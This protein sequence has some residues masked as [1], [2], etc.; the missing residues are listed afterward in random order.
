MPMTVI[1]VTNAPP[2][3]RGD[4]TKWMQ[5]IATGVYIGNFNSR[6]REQLWERVTQ[7]VGRGQATISYTYRNESGYQFQ[8]YQT[9]RQNVNYDGIPL[10]LIP[11]D[12]KESMPKLTNGFSNASIFRKAKKYSAISS[13][14]TKTRRDFVV[15]D[16]E[17]D[18]LSESANQIIEIGA[19]KVEGDHY[20][21]MNTLIEYKGDLPAEI[22]SLTGITT[23]MLHAGGIPISDAL[24]SLSQFVGSLPIVGYS[25]DFDIRFINQQLKKLDMPLLTNKTY[26]LLRFVK[27]EKM[28]LENYRLETALLEYEID[29]KVPH[30]ALEDA[31]LTYEL[32]MKVNGFLKMLDRK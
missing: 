16:I 6:I 31:K 32:A 8:T 28:F 18:G 25:V 12:E 4:L 9:Q 2:S 10:V 14:Q 26:D 20:V 19:V 5:E 22:V 1:T 29:K 7:S 21:T 23:S 30:R 24:N 11:R 27:K 15:V 3:L 17:T 13:T